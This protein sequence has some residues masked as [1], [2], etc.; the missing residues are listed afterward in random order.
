MEVKV[1]VAEEV[2]VKE[3]V[4][5]GV[6]DGRAQEPETTFQIKPLAQVGAGETK[7]SV[8]EPEAPFW[9]DVPPLM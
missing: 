8:A 2:G 1:G 9:V 7:I 5:V 6:E 4:G 3:A